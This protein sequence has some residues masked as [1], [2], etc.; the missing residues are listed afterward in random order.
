M[1][2]SQVEGQVD[3]TLADKVAAG[4]AFLD[5][6]DAD[7]ARVRRRC[8]LDWINGA[9]T[10]ARTAGKRGVA[11]R[12]WYY[13]RPSDAR[14]VSTAMSWADPDPAGRSDRGV[15]TGDGLVRPARREP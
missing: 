6:L 12:D 7:P 3:T 1:K 15:L 14:R 9:I 2:P 8:R 4:N 5:E 11:M 10:A 13:E